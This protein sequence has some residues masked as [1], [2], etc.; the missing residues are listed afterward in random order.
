MKPQQ[1]QTKMPDRY[2]SNLLGV[3]GS[4]AVEFSHLQAGNVSVWKKLTETRVLPAALVFSRADGLLGSPIPTLLLATTRNSYSTQGL[5]STTV[6]LWV[7]P[8]TTS[9]TKGKINMSWQFIFGVINGICKKYKAI[10][11]LLTCCNCLPS[12]WERSPR[13][14]TVDLDWAI[15]IYSRLPG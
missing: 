8:L 6:A 9:G 12:N 13:L 5:K 15:I 11:K 4:A 14:N 7:L 10:L 2:I 3:S 1:P